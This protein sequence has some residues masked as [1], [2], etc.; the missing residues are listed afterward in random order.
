MVRKGW[1]PV[2]G[3]PDGFVS[4]VSH[5]D[6]AAAVVAALDVP[7]GAYNVGDDEPLRRREM[8]DALAS[9]LGVPPPR[10]PP[11]WVVKL[12]GGLAE[13]MARSLRISNRK[14]RQASNWAPRY[15]SIR[16]GWRATLAALD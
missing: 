11:A 5:D 9:A 15:P 3:S 8:V 7:G 1:A 4:S 10:L 12:G 2:P 13:L 14:L 16:E 6:A